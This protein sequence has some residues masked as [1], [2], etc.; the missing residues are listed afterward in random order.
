MALS[1]DEFSKLLERPM[2]QR[3]ADP[4]QDLPTLDQQLA[5][6]RAQPRPWRMPS[7]TEA[8]G[9]PAIQRAV[10]LISNTTGSL[11]IESYRDDVLLT[12][13]PKVITRPDPYQTPDE[14]YGSLGY[15]LATRG[16]FIVYIA[17][18]DPL[19]QATV[20][21][22][23][24]PAEV[25]VEKNERNR[26]FPIYTWG[27]IRGSRFSAANPSGE[28][29]HVTY[30]REPGALRGIGPLQM[31]GA[32]ASVAVEAQE[33]AANFYASGGYPSVLLR[34]SIPLDESE[35]GALKAQ[36]I[37]TP[38]NMPKVVDPGIEEVKEF[39]VNTQGAQ[40]LDSREHQNGEAARMFGIPGALI[41]YGNPGSSLT[42]QNLADVWTQFLKGSLQ[43]NYL[44]KIEQAFSDLLPRGRRVEFNIDGLLRADVK[45]RFE[46]YASGITSG[47]IDAR[48]AQK[49]E[50]I[51][52]GTIEK[53][54]PKPAPEPAPDVAAADAVQSRSAGQVRCDGTRRIK[55]RESRCNAL[56]AEAPPFNGRCWRCGTP[57]SDN[58]PVVASDDLQLR[59]GLLALMAWMTRDQPQPQPAPVN[60]TI[61]EGAIR[62]EIAPA[63][64]PDV[65]V[66]VPPPVVNVPAPIVNVEAPIV[67][68]PAP[69]VNVDTQPL[70]DRIDHMRA[71]LT[72]QR[73]T[74]IVDRDKRGLIV[75]IHEQ[76]AEE[77]A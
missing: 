62:L 9:V 40:M 50:G 34:S 53:P 44:V 29:I 67:N 21:A 11:L 1:M 5:A 68:V 58:L 70:A 28:F 72:P 41:E 27:D 54:A 36:W 47:V 65:H 13:T 51:P 43:P 10:T 7:I 14:F 30:L 52:P 16:E 32:A 8:L 33:W 22:L 31:A 74:K 77:T 46:V 2:H 19:G 45:T 23:V 39:N 61:A 49:A 55:G 6:L 3:M 25:N 57:H 20:L 42:Y 63:P 37:A 59:D 60:V 64:A 71:A 48:Y 73:T 38:A 17:G 35:A 56:L 26:L 12:D 76:L 75:R 18:R 69:V 66:E 15:C 4:W 24:P